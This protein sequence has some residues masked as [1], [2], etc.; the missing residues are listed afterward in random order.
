VAKAAIRRGHSTSRCAELM[1]VEYCPTV[2]RLPRDLGLSGGF[3]CASEADG[4]CSMSRGV[5]AWHNS[6][7]AKVHIEMDQ[8]QFSESRWLIRI[9]LIMMPAPR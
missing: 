3:T 8:V 4:G 5:A 9:G 6:S 2:R 1:L 7:Y